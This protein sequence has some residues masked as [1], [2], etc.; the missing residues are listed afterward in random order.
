MSIFKRLSIL[1]AVLLAGPGISR[2]QH[3]DVLVERTGATLANGALVGGT[4]VTGTANF[5]TSQWAL[6]ARVFNRDFDSTFAISNPGFNSLSAGSPV[7]PADGQPLA[8]NTDLSWDFLPMT[9]SGVS[10]NL[11]YWNGQDTDGVPGLTPNDVRFGALPG[12]GYQLS[13]YDKT[14]T[15]RS[16]NGANAFVPGGVMDTTDS[17]GFIH[18]HR[19]FQLEDGDGD[20]GTVPADGLYLLAMQMRMLGIANSLPVFMV[21]GTPGSSVSAEDDAA[22]PWVEQQLNI[23][24]DYN[25]DGVV[26]AADYVLWR[27]TLD[28]SVATVGS[29]ADGDGDGVIGADDYTFWRQRFGNASQLIVN[30]GAGT[31]SAQG[32]VFGSVPEPT[33][34][35]LLLLGGIIAI[36]QSR[37]RNTTVRF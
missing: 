35:W 1:T 37:R 31:G 21:F 5:T 9:I 13:L 15:K 16:V 32:P 6:G 7:F 33:S 8:G 20:S 22:V 30:T 17:T 10:Q 2:A 24:G 23:P 27:K 28:S 29:G 18:R 26:D 11:F 34:A 36:G 19:F 4:L 14:N 12:S 25:R 3:L